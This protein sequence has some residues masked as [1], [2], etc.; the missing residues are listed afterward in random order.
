MVFVRGGHGGWTGQ[1]GQD[2]K[3][4]VSQSVSKSR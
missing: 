2:S 4:A 3:V 1:D